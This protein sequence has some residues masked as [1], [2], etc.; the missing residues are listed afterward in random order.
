[1][2]THNE[3]PASCFSQQVIQDYDENAQT[4]SVEYA[5]PDDAVRL[6]TEGVLDEEHLADVISRLSPFEA[7]SKEM[8]RTKAFRCLVKRAVA[9]GASGLAICRASGAS[10][11][12]VR[13]VAAELRA[14]GKN[15]N[16]S[17]DIRRQADLLRGERNNR[18][19]ESFRQLVAACIKKELPLTVIELAHA[20]GVNPA[21]VRQVRKEVLGIAADSWVDKKN[22]PAIP[23]ERRLMDRTASFNVVRCGGRHEITCL[24]DRGAQVGRMI[25]E[26]HRASHPSQSYV[27]V[28]DQHGRSTSY[29]SDG[30]RLEFLQKLTGQKL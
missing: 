25:V 20:L 24:D 10:D 30:E 5:I 14:E 23:P 12:Y 9:L 7:G 29:V 4:R 18:Y 13:R 1:M 26:L 22:E 3:E 15:K 28:I 16:L 27:I 2:S 21:Y 19:P 17:D 11:M 8:C 6:T